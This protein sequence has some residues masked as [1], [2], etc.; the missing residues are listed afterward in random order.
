MLSIRYP[1][2]E[3]RS[4]GP[5]RSTTKLTLNKPGNVGNGLRNLIAVYFL[6]VVKKIVW[7]SVMFVIFCVTNEHRTGTTSCVMVI[8]FTAED[9]LL[10][11]LWLQMRKKT[12]FP[13]ILIFV[14]F[15]IVEEFYTFSWIHL[16]KQYILSQLSHAS[17]SF[18][19]GDSV[20]NGDKSNNT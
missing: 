11:Y 2:H 18:F 16:S 4:T 7:M 19:S 10:T 20:D 14:F 8:F 3:R 9:Y 15:K 12:P 17:T 13:I 5:F 1:H 6:Y